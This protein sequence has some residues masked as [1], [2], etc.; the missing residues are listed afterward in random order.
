MQE[1]ETLSLVSAEKKKKGRNKTD[2][3]EGRGVGEGFK[4]LDV[5]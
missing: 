3:M 2:R 4:Q 1:Q 5:G